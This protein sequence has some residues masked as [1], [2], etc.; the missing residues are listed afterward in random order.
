MLVLGP[1]FLGSLESTTHHLFLHSKSKT[2]QRLFEEN[3]YKN[4]KK[5]LSETFSVVANRLI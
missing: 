3:L 1:V 4:E 5:D 2:H